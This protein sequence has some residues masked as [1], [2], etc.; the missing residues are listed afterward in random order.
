MKAPLL[1]ISTNFFRFAT[2][3]APATDPQPSIELLSPMLLTLYF[4]VA[5]SHSYEGCPCR[6]CLFSVWKYTYQFRASCFFYH[7]HSFSS[8]GQSCYDY[9]F[10]QST[11]DQD[12]S[13]LL[14]SALFPL[15]PRWSLHQAFHLRPSIFQGDHV[16]FVALHRQGLCVFFGWPGL[17]FGREVFSFINCEGSI[18][19]WKI[20]V[21]LNAF[22]LSSGWIWNQNGGLDCHR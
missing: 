12:S 5:P 18:V 6:P 3:P 11:Q 9:T 2:F 14:S 16:Q 1:S 8:I 20:S 21:I 7:F 17:L 22:P 10:E 19:H 4:L 15:A 13:F